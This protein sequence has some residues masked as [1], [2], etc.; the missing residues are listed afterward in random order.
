MRYDYEVEHKE[1][2]K[3]FNTSPLT[4]QPNYAQLTLQTCDPPGIP[5]N[6][7]IVTSRLVAE[8]DLN[9]GNN[10]SSL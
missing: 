8:Y 9:N 6:R 4:R 1:I 2:V 7:L 3:G 5:L 10:L